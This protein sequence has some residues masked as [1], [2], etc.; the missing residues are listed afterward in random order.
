VNIPFDVTLRKKDSREAA[1]AGILLWRENFISFL[2]FFAI[3]LWICAFALRLLPGN[4]Q[5]LSWLIL[6][7]LKPLFDRLILHV[8]SIRFFERNAGYKRLLRG[9][10]KSIWRGLL[11]DLL[12]NRFNPLRAA[13]MPVT[14]L[15]THSKSGKEA[16]KRKELLKNGGLRYCFF[17]TFWGIALEITLL[18]GEILFFIIMA[19]LFAKGFITYSLDFF[20]KAEVFVFAAWCFNYM[21]I[22]TLYVCMGFSLYINSRI[23]VEGWDIEIMFRGFAEKLKNKTANGILIGFCLIF[24]FLPSKAFTDDWKPSQDVPLEILQNIFDAPE[25][26]NE[27][28]VWGIRFKRPFEPVDIPDVQINPILER[29]RIIFAAVLRF[30]LICLIAALAAFLFIY[31]RKLIKTRNSNVKKSTMTVLHGISLKDPEELMKKSINFFE[32]GSLRLAWGYCTA[33]AILSW[34][35]YRNLAFPPN[36]TENDC[37][38]IVNSVSGNQ[39]EALAFCALIN[40]WINFAYAGRLPPEGSFEEALTF[41]KCLR[42]A[43]G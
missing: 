13:M 4:T 31:A 30:I 2:P 42:A 29:L 38:N 22:G 12:W 32:Q 39:T 23:N 24:L 5:Y 25:F 16:E 17:L 41:C 9:L 1:D 3:P 18:V 37:A 33:A 34:S 10:G 14:V 43:N 15:E 28:E 20:I 36:A 35:I 21:I 6:W 40:H 26:G 19:D 27:K 7:L 11:G 8:I